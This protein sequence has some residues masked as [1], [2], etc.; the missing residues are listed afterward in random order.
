MSLTDLLPFNLSKRAGW[1]DN[2]PGVSI[3]LLYLMLVIVPVVASCTGLA[4]LGSV[5]TETPGAVTTATIE[6]S[7][8]ITS[9]EDSLAT[10]IEAGAVITITG[11]VREVVP[12]DKV[13]ILDSEVIEG[14]QAFLLQMQPESRVYGLDNLEID[15]AGIEEGMIIQVMG[16]EREDGILL[17]GR[18]QVLA[19]PLPALDPPPVQGSPT[20]VGP[21]TLADVSPD[22]ELYDLPEFGIKLS[23]PVDWEMSR[24]P[25]SYFFAPAAPSGQNYPTQLTVGHQLNVPAEPESLATAITEQWQRLTPLADFYATSIVVDG[26]EG[27]ALWNLSPYSCVAVYIAAHDVVYDIS[28]Y[29]AFCNKVGNELN[30]F[31]QQVLA[32]IV[33][34]EPTESP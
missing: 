11:R 15:L 28:F 4:E 20:P 19:L 30:D 25:G 29:S 10:D 21:I 3:T 12:A 34:Y 23:M 13:I 22:W 14:R 16:Q 6:Q 9:A 33:L 26:Y 2:L 31:G 7:G 27:V 1:R 18:V 24:M 5:E 32:S 8:A 17:T